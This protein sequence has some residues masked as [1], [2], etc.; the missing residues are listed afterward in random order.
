MR[1]DDAAPVVLTGGTSGIGRA[2]ALQFAARGL[3][4]VLGVRDPE[5]GEDVKS[6]ILALNPEARVDLIPLDLSDL[7][8]VLEFAAAYA[9]RFPRWRAL[10]NNAGVT[11]AP[12]RRLTA[13]GFELHLGINHLGHFALTGLLLP[14]AAEDARVVTVT[15]LAARFGRILFHD[16]RF[17]HGYRSFRAYAASMRANLLFAREL[18]RKADEEGLRI[19]SI[20][21]HPGYSVPAERLRGPVGLPRRA[22]GQDFA[23][24]A[25]PLVTA[26]TDPALRGGELIGPAGLGHTAGRPVVIKP[27]RIKNEEQVAKRLWRLSGQLTRVRW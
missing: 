21:A 19:R 26:A 12:S 20:A 2:A 17:D 25:A 7:A 22:V 6:E 9:A 8:S 23:A 27:P 10:V 4:L 1:D 11:L 18:Q 5:R 24:G 3:P 16:L 13:D 14:S 15:S